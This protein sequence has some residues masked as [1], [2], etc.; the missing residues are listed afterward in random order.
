MKRFYFFLRL[1]LSLG[2]IIFLIT[3]VDLN[4]LTQVL[5]QG[6]LRLIALAYF[7]GILDRILMAYKWRILLQARQIYL[8]LKDAT[9]L[10]L[11]CTFLGLLLPATVGGDIFRAYAVTKDEDTVGDVIS[12][13]V[14]ERVLGLVALM[15]FVIFSILLSILVMGQGFITNVWGLLGV[16]VVLL[17]ATAVILILSFTQVNLSHFS[18]KIEPLLRRWQYLWQGRKLTRLVQNTYRSY[19]KYRDNKLELALFLFY[20]FLENL[21]PIFWSYC[22][23]RAF[24]IDVP[25]L[26][27][28]ILVP[29]VLALRRLPI[30]I[31]GIG[32]QQGAYVYFLSLI[33]VPQ[34]ESL[35]LGIGTH[36]L[37]L[38]IILPGGLF[39]IFGGLD[40]KEAIRVAER[41]LDT[42]SVEVQPDTTV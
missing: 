25:L 23:A 15:V 9:I 19:L 34:A 26:F 6:S 5:A 32:V 35:L 14:L 10:Y 24:G 21:F 8:S 4:E 3:L 40:Y 30:S 27:F 29:L 13:I 11:T 28:F 37:A 38:A 20:S 31:D 12:S 1:F 16:L 18:C 39:Y 36:L 17:G 42:V 41:G 22:L 33:N 7:L 2:L